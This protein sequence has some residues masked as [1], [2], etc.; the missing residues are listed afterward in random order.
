MQKRSNPNGP[1][2]LGITGTIAS[3]KSTVGRLLAERGI[4][5]IDTDQLTHDVLTNDI[6]VKK[7]IVEQFGPGVLEGADCENASSKN[8]RPESNSLGSNNPDRPID[9]KN[10]AKIVFQNSDSRR[11]LEQIVH[12]SV[13][14]SCRRRIKELS[15]EKLVAVLVP[16]LFEVNMADE[17]DEIWT[18]FTSE[19]VLKQR[20]GERDKLD[21]LEIQRRLQAQL[22]QSEKCSRA[23]Q[24]IDNSHSEAETA[25]QVNLLIE[26]LL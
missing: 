16:L 10:L 25:R 1:I 17:Y 7:A 14:L 9:R 15:S 12:P 6:S 5:V 18:V 20:L 24:V 4:P 21:A 22:P 23:D 19:E 26:K 8:D 3:G 11:K 13:V 2:I